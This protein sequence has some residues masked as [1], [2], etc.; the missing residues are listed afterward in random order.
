MLAG[1]TGVDF[2]L[3][4]VAADDGPMPQTLEHLHILNLLGLHRGI[5]ALSKADLVSA[6]RLAEMAA[7]IRALLA[8]TRL[9]GA[10][11]IPV[12]SVTGEGVA[13]LQDR[14]L[15]AATEEIPRETGDHFRLAVDRN[16]TL[17][18]V[19]TVVTGTAFAGEVSVGNRLC[20]T[21]SGI[22]VRVRSLHVH[23][24]P[25]R[26]VRAGQRC[27][28]ALTG[29]HLDRDRIRRGDWLVDPVLHRPADRLDLCLRLLATERR[30]LA[31]WTPVHLHLGAAHVPA[32]VALLSRDALA[33]GEENLAQLVPDRPIGALRGDRVILRPVCSAHDR[34]Q[35][36]SRP[37]AAGAGS[38]PFTAVGDAASPPRRGARIGAATTGRGR[39]RVDR[40]RDLRPSLEPQGRS[41]AGSM[42]RGRAHRRA[43]AGSDVRPDP[44]PLGDGATGG[45]GC[46][47]GL[48]RDVAAEP[49]AGNG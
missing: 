4:V 38:P 7:A 22:E 9:A 48:P 27:A 11:I 19:G 34:R 45:D 13:A 8:G 15:A 23:D 35:R 49:R 43:R 39:A 12:S 6:G 40:P 1:T 18:G 41:G 42:S 26:H 24:R 29:D 32:R 30:P 31:H 3:L 17:A 33:P 2:V 46:A 16:F 36:R 10:Q 37:L 25:A 5:V 14:L 20:L 21:P 47:R 44:R 28:A